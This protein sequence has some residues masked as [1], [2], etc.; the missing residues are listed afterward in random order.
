MGWVSN[1]YDRLLSNPGVRHPICPPT[2]DPQSDLTDTPGVRA[3]GKLMDIQVDDYRPTN[4]Y[5]GWWGA[6]TPWPSKGAARRSNGFTYVLQGGHIGSRE[7]K[8]R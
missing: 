5:G 4:R 6:W 8:I 7:Y 3:K 2:S 1:F